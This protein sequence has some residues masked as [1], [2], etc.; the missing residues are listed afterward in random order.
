MRIDVITLFPDAMVELTG[1]GVTGRAIRDGLVEL[2]TWNPRDFAKDRHRTVDGRP[3][4]GGPGMVMKVEPLGS[5][6]RAARKAHVDDRGD[7]NVRVSL[8][9]DRK[10]TRLNSSHTDISRMPSSA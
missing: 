5:A 3:Y 2:E 7:E 6:I 4:G 8:M 10:S 9:R 1:L